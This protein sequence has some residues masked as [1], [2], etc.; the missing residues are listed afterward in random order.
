MLE[1]KVKNSWKIYEEEKYLLM[2][3]DKNRKEELWLTS[4]CE[5]E[6]MLK[7]ILLKVGNRTIL[8]PTQQVIQIDQNSTM[9]ILIFFTAS[10][11]KVQVNDLEKNCISIQRFIEQPMF[12]VVG[13]EDGTLGTSVRHFDSLSFAPNST[14]E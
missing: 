8:E 6:G 11:I 10:E 3:Q 1:I 5:K 14:K 9:K 12:V 7:L 2:I 13:D 4:I